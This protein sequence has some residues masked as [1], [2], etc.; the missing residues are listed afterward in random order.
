MKIILMITITAAAAQ[1]TPDI[2]HV[3]DATPTMTAGIEKTMG[4]KMR[5]VSSRIERYLGESRCH[6]YAG[7]AN[8]SSITS[9][10]YVP[11]PCV[12][13][14]A[15]RSAGILRRLID[16]DQ[17]AGRCDRAI[18]QR[19]PPVRTRVGKQPQPRP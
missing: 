19:Q 16:T 8:S 17:N 1:I 12:I 14:V 3:P 2:H 7:G 5:V 10:G 4:T 15:T 9:S 18:H 6:W 11:Q 13:G